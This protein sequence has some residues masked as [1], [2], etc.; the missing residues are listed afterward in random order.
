MGLL[1]PH[2]LPSRWLR[3]WGQE[4]SYIPHGDLRALNKPNPSTNA[5]KLCQETSQPW[6]DLLPIAP[7]QVPVLLQA[8]LQLSP[9]EAPYGK[10]FL[11]CGTLSDSEPTNLLYVTPLGQFQEGL[12]AYAQKSLT[13]PAGW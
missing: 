4:I 5:K 6:P 11:S 9:H 7:L 12:R 8:S 2:I 3:P 1:L 10:A 13:S